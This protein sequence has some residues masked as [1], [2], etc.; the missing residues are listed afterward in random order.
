MLNST[1]NSV[2][3]NKCA[4]VLEFP[5]NLII[6]RFSILQ[7]QNLSLK[8]YGVQNFA[9]LFFRGKNSHALKWR[10]GGLILFIECDRVG[11]VVGFGI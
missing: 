1:K 7:A 6:P 8:M 9:L 3:Q 10:G 5:Y 2:F 4:G 11:I